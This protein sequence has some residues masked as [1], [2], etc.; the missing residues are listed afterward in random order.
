[1]IAVHCHYHIWKIFPSQLPIIGNLHQLGT[2]PHQSLHALS[3]KYGP[4]MFLNFGQTPTL[5]V[6]SADVA[7]EMLKTRDVAFSNRSKTTAA[8][9]LFYACTNVGF[10]PYG[11]YWRQARK[12][13]VLELLSLKKVQSFQY[14][15]EEEI[16]ALM[17][18]IHESCS[19]GG[20][21]IK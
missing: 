6:S 1:M 17:K 3:N 13:C 16:K 8:D 20:A 4:L 7:R 9:A 2:L 18:K 11:E 21:F 14:V 19:K 5:V 12:I 10:S 15:R